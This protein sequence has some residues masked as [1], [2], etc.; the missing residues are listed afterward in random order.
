MSLTTP[1]RRAEMVVEW[2]AQRLML[3]K[4]RNKIADDIR[5]LDEL[6]GAFGE[7]ERHD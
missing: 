3:V 4:Y 7:A 2:R 5:C 1:A 6:I